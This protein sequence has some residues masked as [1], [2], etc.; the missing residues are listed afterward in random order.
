MAPNRIARNGFAA[1]VVLLI[2]G[3]GLPRLVFA[4]ESPGTARSVYTAYRF[5]AAEE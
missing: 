2:A 5:D 4:G 1:F 3:F